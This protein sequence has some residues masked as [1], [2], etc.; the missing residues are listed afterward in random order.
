MLIVERVMMIAKA[1]K[2][3]LAVN[4]APEPMNKPKAK[5]KKRMNSLCRSSR[6]ILNII[7]SF[8]FNF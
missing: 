6:R 4:L 3:V 1:G 7:I 5:A 2:T 8:P